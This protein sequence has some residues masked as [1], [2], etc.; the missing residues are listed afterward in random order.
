MPKFSSEAF[1]SFTLHILVSSRKI[2]EKV[3][4]KNLYNFQCNRYKN[5]CEVIK[6]NL[7]FSSLPLDF[8]F[9]TPPFFYTTSNQ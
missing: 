6:N 3:Y 2:P 5:S 4:I 1:Q 9:N 8:T 7:E